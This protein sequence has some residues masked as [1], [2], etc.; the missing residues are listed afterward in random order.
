MRS[1]SLGLRTL[2]LAA[3]LTLAAGGT[4]LAAQ[5]DWDNRYDGWRQSA[6][7]RGYRD[8]FQQGTHDARGRRAF[9]YD[10]DRRYRD[11]DDGYQRHY[12]DRGVYQ[13]VFRQGFVTGYSAG[14][15]G[16]N[17][18][19]VY[20]GQYPGYAPYSYGRAVPRTSPGYAT[21]DLAWTN[22]RADG[23]EKGLEDGRRNR[24]FQPSRHDRYEDADHG[25]KKWYGPK[26][27]YRQ[28]YRQAFV[29]GYDAGYRDGQRSEG[30][31][32]GYRR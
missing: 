3:G 25:Y 15:Y 27:Y 4:A 16:R 10:H 30:R 18:Y 14:Y 13:Q 23:Y 22:G 24:S 9:A 12:G 28:A 2:V 11:A 7:D 8:G 32:Y 20:G 21:N 19:S 29:T 6:Y 31:G 5:R 26:D 17:Q 1:G